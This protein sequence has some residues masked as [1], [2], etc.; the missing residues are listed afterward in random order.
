MEE[1]KKIS[2]PQWKGCIIFGIVNIGLVLLCTKLNIIMLSVSLILLIAA[3]VVITMQSIKEDW[4]E[5]FKLSVVGCVIGL[6]LNCFAAVLYVF[7]ILAGIIGMF[8]RFIK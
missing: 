6:L 4:R 7:N 2:T 1:K 5:G 8:S 3:G